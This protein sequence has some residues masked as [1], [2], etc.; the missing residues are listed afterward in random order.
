MDFSENNPL[1]TVK[2]K[3]S[4]ATFVQQNGLTEK[5]IKH[6]QTIPNYQN[7]KNDIELIKYV[8]KMIEQLVKAGNS[9]LPVGQKLDKKQLALTIL[10]QLFALN[11]P[12]ILFI[13][14]LIDFLIANDLVKKKTCLSKLQDAV[15]SSLPTLPK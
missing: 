14:N 3:N 11:Q 12:E 2:V 4:L 13:G 6:I 10:Q 15:Y 5:L 7:L 8:C 9:A 1:A